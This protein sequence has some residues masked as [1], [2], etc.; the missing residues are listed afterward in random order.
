MSF[1]SWV[2]LV[3]A[4]TVS[5]PIFG[6]G[7]GEKRGMHDLIALSSKNKERFGVC[8]MVSDCLCHIK[9]RC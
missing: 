4:E 1:I 9:S 5:F 8:K 7:G 2:I 3:C 6:K